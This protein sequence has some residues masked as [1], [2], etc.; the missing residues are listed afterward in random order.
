MDAIY[1]LNNT[2]IPIVNVVE[3]LNDK[4]NVQAKDDSY[5][6]SGILSAIMSFM[7]EIKAGKLRQFNTELKNIHL[8]RNKDFS[9]AIITDLN[10]SIEPSLI[11]EM[12]KK[13]ET[14][15]FFFLNR[16]KGEISFLPETEY[17][18]LEQK[19]VTIVREIKSKEDEEAVKRIKESLW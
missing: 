17:E 8:Y 19:I 1:I 12:F 4:S 18:Q 14:E 10:D 6:F 13:I 16:A 7:E 3:P 2:G 5:L 15:V 9:I 11:E